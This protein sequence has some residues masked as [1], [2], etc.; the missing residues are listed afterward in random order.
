MLYHL[1]NSQ[2]QGEWCKE[3]HKF[4]KYGNL[5][6]FSVK[7]RAILLC[8]KKHCFNWWRPGIDQIVMGLNASNVV[9]KN[10]FFLHR[11]KFHSKG[12]DNA[13]CFKL[14]DDRT[15]HNTATASTTTKTKD[16]RQITPVM[17]QKTTE[18]LFLQTIIVLVNVRGETVHL[19]AQLHSESKQQIFNRSCCTTPKNEEKHRRF[20]IRRDRIPRP[21]GLGWSFHHIKERII[22]NQRKCICFNKIDRQS[23]IS[24]HWYKPMKNSQRIT[25]GRH[26][27]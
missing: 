9:E 7:E 3:N 1:A 11:E 27:L 23:A 26:R 6:K 17:A 10:V 18:N 16:E 2:Q 25:V 12:T 20:R 19:R 21:Q 5:K 13:T 24:F 4:F 8:V 22:I 15:N 14:V